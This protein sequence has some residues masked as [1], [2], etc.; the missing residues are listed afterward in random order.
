VSPRRPPLDFDGKIPAS[1]SMVNRAAVIRSFEERVEVRGRSSCDDV[2]RLEGALRVMGTGV[3][4]DC[5]EGGTVF[6]FLTARASRIPG[7]HELAC[8]PSLFARPHD[9]LYDALARLGIRVFRDRAR[10][11]VVV[12]GRGWRDPGRPVPVSRDVS[13]QFA[14]AVLLSA[15]DLP[16]SLALEAGQD[17]PSEPY[18]S[19]TLEMLRRAGMEWRRTGTTLSVPPM[20]HPAAG[21]RLRLEPD[22]SSAFAL[23]ALAAVAGR[24]RIHEFPAE[25]LQPDAAFVGILHRMGAPVCRDRNGV[26]EVRS[27]AGGVRAL[28]G[29][30]VDLG[31]SPDLFPVLAVL[32]SFASGPSRLAGAPHLAHK[33]SDRIRKTAELIALVGREATVLPDGLRVEEGEPRFGAERAYDP[34]GDHRL[35]MAAH[36]AAAAGAPI[37]ILH[38]EVVDKSFPEYWPIVLGG[39]LA[40]TTFLAGQRGVG[41]SSLLRRLLVAARDRGIALHALDLDGEIERREGVPIPDLFEAG[42]EARFRALE[43]R[44]LEAVLEEFA[45]ARRRGEP[46]A[47]ALGAGFE[48]FDLPV[49]RSPLTRVIWVRR[50]TDDDG[51][52]LLDRPRLDA[53]AT[54]LAEFR[55]RAR[56]RGARFR[57]IADRELVLREGLPETAG[58]ERD[59]LLLGRARLGAWL[60]MPPSALVRP[61]GIARYWEARRDW[62]IERVELRDDLLPPDRMLAAR[63]GIPDERLVVSFRVPGAPVPR[64]L[65]PPIEVDWALELG[66]PPEGLRPTIASLH[67]RLPGESLASALDRLVETAPA[68]TPR[69]KAA[70]EVRDFA[71]LAAGDAWQRRDPHRRSFLPRSPDGRWSWYR[72][73]QKG[74][75][76]MGFVRDGG[77]A[78]PVGAPDQPTLLEWLD[79]RPGLSR[80]GA[81]LGDPVAA[82]RSP[83]LHLAWALSRGASY[84]AIRVAET[85]FDEAIAVLEQLG[86]GFA[87]VTAPLKRAALRLAGASASPL[88]AEAG[89]VNTLLRE[90]REAAWTGEN[91][92]VPGLAASVEEWKRAE[93]IPDLAAL[94]IAL[95]GGG[96]TLEAMRRAFPG[97]V[98][99]SA[100]TGQPR[101]GSL[102]SGPWDV[103]VWAVPRSRAGACVAPGPD[104]RPRLVFDLDYREN[105]PGREFALACGARYFSGLH[106]LE[107]QAA[108][109]QRY[110]SLHER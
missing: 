4:L 68:G 3:S 92:D 49:F 17:G 13:S 52:I 56:D 31:R 75:Q 105:S 89:A 78:G 7:R 35:A 94:R 23:A 71:E 59:L 44:T 63:D 69:L 66:P 64:D 85:E 41:K 14:S 73:R 62:G 12:E 72:L 43:R 38:K 88:A 2:R 57:E 93:A 9:G 5:G 32:A 104:F 82:S 65:D 39:G 95:W 96:G 30:D 16:F 74:R 46:A 10:R 47:I 70:P 40:E 1:K 11:V 45:A 22:V 83:A 91:T 109:Q 29:I 28:E 25:S 8:G 50:R 108:L 110:W 42:G 86:L 24:A 77:D 36:V 67:E 80:F 84:Y 34:A 107:R 18:L 55:S 99:F 48:A 101:D 15:W 33:E 97:A 58:S 20:Q 76:A 53:S 37:E 54:P 103:V 87:S 19:M 26:L 21:T 60:T 6:R 98:A 90:G 106:F 81:V 61:A 27:P 51:R 102:A 79:E 100:R